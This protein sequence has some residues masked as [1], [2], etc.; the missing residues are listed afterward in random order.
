M[1]RLRR[2]PA[3]PLTFSD[4]TRDRLE[5]TNHWL[6]PLGLGVHGAGFFFTWWR[7]LGLGWAIALALTFSVPLSEYSLL[8]LAMK[9]GVP[10]AF[11]DFGVRFEAESWDLH[12]FG[13]RGTAHKVKLLQDEGSAPVFTA[14]EIEFNAT[15]GALVGR[16]RNK[17]QVFDSITV[18][19]AEVHLEQSL[20]GEWNWMAFLD[21]VP[22][23]R[24]DAVARGQ[25][26]TR[27]LN[28]ERLHVVYLENIPSNSGG[29]VIQTAQARIY[30]DDVT[31]SIRD[32]IVPQSSGDLPTRF[33]WKGRSSDGLVQVS[34]RGAFFAP[35]NGGGPPG[36]LTVKIYLENIGMGAYARMVS[37]TSLMP[38]RG[39]LRG[40]IDV[41][42]TPSGNICAANLVA[43]DVQFAPNPRV[44]LAR[45]QYDQLQNDLRSYKASGA[46]DPCEGEYTQQNATAVLASFNAQTTSHASAAVRLAAVRDQKNFGLVLANSATNDLIDRLARQVGRRIPGGAVGAQTGQTLQKEKPN[47][48]TKGVQTIGKGFKKLFGK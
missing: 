35:D 46:F 4:R 26:Q 40:T 43:E 30:V 5:K 45:S 31:G 18:R 21:T 2:P 36:L 9:H 25:Y 3:E 22:K 34:G 23:D 37:T 42:S 24:R 6:E 33:Q 16:L 1:S 14:N 15:L 38:V 48:V 17:P 8:N 47:A 13:V 41:R 29:G 32:L 44:V 10:L 28:F 27:A 19:D 7:K 39:T 20:A 11:G 12:L